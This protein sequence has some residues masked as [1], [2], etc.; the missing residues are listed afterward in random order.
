M[1][2]G[3][4]RCFRQVGSTERLSLRISSQ[5]PGQGLD[6]GEGGLADEIAA[7]PPGG[8][9]CWRT[10]YNIKYSFFF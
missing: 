9:T 2:Q 10:L 5:S 7:A 4:S 3:A 1:G 8:F 6:L